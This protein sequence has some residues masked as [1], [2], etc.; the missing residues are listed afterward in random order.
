[1]EGYQDERGASLA[2]AA[3]M[4]EL[5]S[6]DKLNVV[7]HSIG[8]SRNV[9]AV[10][11]QLNE[12]IELCELILH[13]GEVITDRSIQDRWPEYSQLC[14]EADVL[15]EEIAVQHGRSVSVRREPHP[16]ASRFKRPFVKKRIVHLQRLLDDRTF[17]QKEFENPD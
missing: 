14:A 2:S 3:L 8:D 11:R 16:G 10:C 5:S 17:R 6:Q 13:H 1:M 9:A 4:R 7:G 15:S 12:L